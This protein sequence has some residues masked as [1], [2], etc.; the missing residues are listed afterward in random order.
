MALA[1]YEHRMHRGIVD[2]AQRANW[3]LD[4]S[5]GHYGTPPKFWRGE[6]VVALILPDRP[7]LVRYVRRLDLPIVSL[8][9]DMAELATVQVTIDNF[10][11]GRIAAEH[12]IERGFRN[13]VFYKCT[14]YEDVRRR[15]A[16]FASRVKEAGL[17]YTC[18]NWYAAARKSARSNPFLWLRQRLR[19][20]PSPMGVMA[21][22]DHR[23]YFLVNVCEHEGIRVPEQVAVVG[24]DNDE[25]TCQFAPIPISSVDSNREKLAFEAA[26]I[27]DRLMDGEEPPQSPVLVPPAGLVVRQS[28]DILSLEHPEVAKALGFIW[29]HFHY[30]IRVNDVVAATAMSRCDL[31]REFRKYLG[32]TIREEIERKR[33]ELAR[34][35]LTT[36][37]H[38]I[39]HVA[40]SSGFSSGEQFCRTFTKST[41]MTPSVFRAQQ[42]DSSM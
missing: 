29:K 30:R 19:R 37:E 3:I 24:V 42:A 17:G 16:G 14:D 39:A 31:Y 9:G 33:I 10:E 4:S 21:Q 15:E 11:V 20:L 26:A 6:G 12:L 7:D 32:R 1:Y 5:M 40:R 36:T 38:K 41:G 22:S 2:Y 28:S 8:T 34:R 23:A 18:L 27:L 25:Y 13:L 35:L